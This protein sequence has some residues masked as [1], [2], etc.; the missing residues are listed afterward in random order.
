MD[1][2]DDDN[3]AKL[4]PAI[5]MIIKGKEPSSFG[6]L[7]TERKFDKNKLDQILGKHEFNANPN[8]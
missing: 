5:R 4:K 8:L 6:I 1:S 2:L 3:A 7:V